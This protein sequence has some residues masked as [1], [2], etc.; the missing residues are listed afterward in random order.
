MENKM[1]NYPYTHFIS[2]HKSAP[3]K[4]LVIQSMDDRGC[5]IRA[6][7]ILASMGICERDEKL[8]NFK[9]EVTK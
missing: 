1:T 2:W 4:R 6:R 8:E 3:D 9:L 5:K 7:K